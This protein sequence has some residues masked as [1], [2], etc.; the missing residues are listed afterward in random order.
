MESLHE[1]AVFIF[2]SPAPQKRGFLLRAPINQNLLN[3]MFIT[4]VSFCLRSHTYN[5][6]HDGY[7]TIARGTPRPTYSLS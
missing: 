7:E 5:Q 1:R 3:Y 6:A 2:W 4:F